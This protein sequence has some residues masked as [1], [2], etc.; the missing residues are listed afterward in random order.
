MPIYFRECHECGKLSPLYSRGC[1][2]P[3]TRDEAYSI[4]SRVPKTIDDAVKG[5]YVDTCHICFYCGSKLYDSDYIIDDNTPFSTYSDALRESERQRKYELN[6]IFPKYIKD[7]SNKEELFN[8]RIKEDDEKKE[9]SRIEREKHEKEIDEY[10]ERKRAEETEKNIP[11]C[12]TCGSTDVRKID[13][14]ER[15]VSVLTLGLF[16]K[17]INKSFKC[18]NC[19]YTW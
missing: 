13:A 17:K 14:L 2:R 3:A 10:L 11:H 18:K 4:V 16:S 19:G 9:K 12:P 1:P 7:D 15:G 8:T 6:V 5:I